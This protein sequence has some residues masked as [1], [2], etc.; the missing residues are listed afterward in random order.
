[1][2]YS[3]ESVSC[4]SPVNGQ[5][6]VEVALQSHKEIDATL[7]RAVE[8]QRRWALT[9]LVERMAIIDKAVSAF[10]AKQ[11]E[12]A[13]EITWQMG[14][15]ISHSPG[16]VR[17]F[18]ER[19]RAM[20]A[21]APSALSAL[22][23]PERA[24]FRRRIERIPLGVVAVI[25]PWNYPYLTAV[26]AIIPALLAGNA[27]V[28]K[29]SHQTPLCA[30]R[31]TECLVAA[32]LPEGVF[33]TLQLTHAD[34]ALLMRDARIA[35]VAFTGS[36]SGG[37]AVVEAIS[38]GFATAGLELGGKDA[39]Y[40]RED[41]NLSAAIETL[42]DGAFYNAG[43]SCCG[44]KRIY[45]AKSRY[46][47]FVD[48]VVDLTSQYRLGNPTDPNTNLGPVVRANAADGLRA[49]VAAAV[50]MGASNLINV[51][52]FADGGPG[53]PYMAPVVMSGVTQAMP[54]VQEETF[55]PVVCILPV[56]GDDEAVHFIND[57]AFGLTSAI[58]SQDL[59]VSDQLAMRLETGTVFVNRCDY[60][61]PYLA[62][63]GYKHSGRGAT[64]SA[65]GFEQLTR[66]H[67][68]HIKEL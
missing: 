14:R 63:A 66:P 48:G 21:L 37:R 45:V 67:S 30:T 8:A 2:N 51:K 52:Q 1:M 55:G 13:L 15:P 64:L 19:A 62:W 22:V 25:A 24:G 59:H 61:D 56:S 5:V 57:S 38:H 32:Q 29:H 58:F 6:Y 41:A 36:V 11:T 20:L 31:F 40:V 18:E 16:E 65:V 54:I 39:A 26:N 9:P 60:L 42:T 46:Q 17:G 49:Q 43:Q 50:A 4:I 47:A 10:V 23:P 27:V 33:S 34:T 44:I 68:I 28:L 53:S 35:H 7:S 3:Q 12:I